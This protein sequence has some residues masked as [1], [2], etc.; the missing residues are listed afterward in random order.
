MNIKVFSQ[1]FNHEIYSLGFPEEVIEKI[2]AVMKVFKVPR[3][4]ANSMLSG[5]HILPSKDELDRIA[6]ILEVCPHWLSG[7]TNKRKAYSKREV[8]DA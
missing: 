1:R 5:G 8:E 4:L 3:Q 7:K 6:Q 2:K